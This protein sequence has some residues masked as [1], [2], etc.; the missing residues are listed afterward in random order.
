MDYN[1][2]VQNYRGIPVKLIV[3]KDYP[4]RQAKRY[5]LNDTNQNVWIPNKHLHPDGTIRD[6]EDL[7]YVFRAHGHQLNIAGITW[8]IPGIKRA[9]VNER[10]LR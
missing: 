8:A 2:G 7:D 10:K 3:R 6:G 5:T 4:F 9:Q 1:I